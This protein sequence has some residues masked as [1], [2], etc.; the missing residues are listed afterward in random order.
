M[1]TA[2]APEISEQMPVHWAA[3]ASRPDTCGNDPSTIDSRLAFF[4][5]SIASG[6]TSVSMG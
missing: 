3:G 1:E 5:R 4:E 2:E 6:V